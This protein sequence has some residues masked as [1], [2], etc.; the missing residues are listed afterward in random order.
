MW[1]KIGDPVLHIELRRWADILVVCPASADTMAKIVSGM[2]DNLLL[3]VVRAWEFNRKPSILC[4]AMN[5]I[6]FEQKITGITI[7]SLQEDG[8]VIVDPVTKKLACN[9]KGIGA[10]APVNAI[11]SKIHEVALLYYESKEYDFTQL[12]KKAILTPRHLRIKE[13]N[14]SISLSNDND[15]VINNDKISAHSIVSETTAV[16]LVALTV[17]MV[18]GWLYSHCGSENK[19]QTAIMLPRLRR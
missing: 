3:S 11:I 9:D 5:T 7:K 16:A 13:T 18:V 17:G 10:L 1:N 19:S 15:N 4:P 2:A 8:F 12:E 14:P 6:M